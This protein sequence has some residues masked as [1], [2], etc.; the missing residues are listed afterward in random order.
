M[1][2]NIGDSV[3]RLGN[4]TIKFTVSDIHHDGIVVARIVSTNGYEAT[5]YLKV[6]EWELE[7]DRAAMLKE[8]LQD[9]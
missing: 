2:F 5:T 3:F 7:H 8:V 9:G 1:K 6:A 4:K